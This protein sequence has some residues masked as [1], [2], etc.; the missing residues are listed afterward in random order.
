MHSLAPSVPA[1]VRALLDSLGIAAQ[2]HKESGPSAAQRSPERVLGPALSLPETVL[3]AE[4]L[5]R[6]TPSPE[7]LGA[8]LDREALSKQAAQRLATLRARIERS[9]E[10]A[11]EGK[12]ALPDAT[13]L[14]ARI[15]GSDAH[16]LGQAAARRGAAVAL[17][18]GYA[19]LFES[20]L[21]A[22]QREIDLYKGALRATVQRGCP[23]G[24][25]LLA[26]DKALDPVITRELRHTHRGLTRAYERSCAA[27]IETALLALPSDPDIA[28]LEPLFAPRGALGRLLHDARRLISALLDLEWSM[29]Q[30]LLDAFCAEQSAL[31]ARREPR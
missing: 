9:Y 18:Q 6:A 26:L 24:S 8:E 23:R 1:D 28:A 2:G 7:G 22:M 15:A 4:A 30:G 3:V 21:G 11:F 16:D 17:S 13:R 29:V 12:S 31:F 5:S 27:R 10:D 25:R 19:E 14:H 20:T